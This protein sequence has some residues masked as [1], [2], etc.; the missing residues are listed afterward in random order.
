MA[1]TKVKGAVWDIADQDLFVSVKDLAYGAKGDNSTD[2][3]TAINAAI[4]AVNSAGGGVVYFPE[5]TYICDASIV[6][7]STVYLVGAG[8]GVTTLYAKDSA[9]IHLVNHTSA[10]TDVGVIGMTL[11]G[12]R[13]NQ[14][15]GVHSL[16]S[17]AAITRG[18]FK[19]LHVK[20]GY[21][22]N[23]GFQAGDYTDVLFEDIYSEGSGDDSIDFKNT[24]DASSG[25]RLNNIYVNGWNV[26]ANSN[27]AGIDLRGVCHLTNI[28]VDAGSTTTGDCVRF[29]S[30]ALLDASGYG[31]HRS[32]LTN[33]HIVGNDNTTNGINSGA[34]DVAISNGHIE[35]CNVDIVGSAA[36][37]KVSNVT[38]DTALDYSIKLNSGATDWT[39]SNC[40]INTPADNCVRV[41]SGA[42]NATITGCRFIMAAGGVEVVADN[43]IVE[44]C[45]FS[46]TGTPITFSGS[47]CVAG[48]N[49]GAD[50]ETLTSSSPTVSS[51]IPF[52]YIDSTSNGVGGTLG[53]GH[54]PGFIKTIAMSAFTNSS[55][56]TVTNHETSDP[57]VFTFD[58]VDETLVLMWTGT[59]WITIANSNVTT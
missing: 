9:D 27:T 23:I 43:C 47:G 35:G 54:R 29:R 38:T 59:E 19:D 44:G 11:D 18:V 31:A 13:A 49:V 17:G 56:V 50:S 48:N 4:T 37:N 53:D 36:R 32:S 39:I 28:F 42:D 34:T 20:N 12:N 24:E 1:L 58:A 16:R 26:G 25:I 41:E 40:V 22:Y 10:V 6:L 51:V 30:G 5:G 14:S 52:T 2:D 15:S 57:E 55:T 45:N 21:T 46:G 3:S 7:Q 33:F 8:R